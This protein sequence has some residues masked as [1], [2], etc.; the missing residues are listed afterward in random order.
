MPD[1]YVIVDLLGYR[2]ITEEEAEKKVKTGHFTS[3]GIQSETASGKT[4]TVH[5]IVPSFM[6]HGSEKKLDQEVYKYLEYVFA[7]TGMPH[8]SI[9][10]IY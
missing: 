1:V 8:G 4:W 3:V 7:I 10:Q 9:E 6:Y 5:L 2:P